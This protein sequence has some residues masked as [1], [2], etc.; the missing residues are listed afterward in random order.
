M[1]QSEAAFQ[2]YSCAYE[3]VSVLYH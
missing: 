2:M 1:G 3:V